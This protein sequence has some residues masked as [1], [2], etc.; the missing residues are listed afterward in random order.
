M[1]TSGGT[2]RW[3]ATTSGA[4]WGGGGSPTARPAGATCWRGPPAGARRAAGG[5]EGAWGSGRGLAQHLVEA[6]EAVVEVSPRRTAAGRKRARRP[7]T[8]DRLDALAVARLVLGAA[9]E[10]AVLDLLTT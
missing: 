10:P 4:R 6:G 9:A 7:G 1:P 5:V 2:R 8:S 3:R